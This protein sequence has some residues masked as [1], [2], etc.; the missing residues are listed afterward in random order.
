MPPPNPPSPEHGHIRT[1]QGSD[2]VY[3][4]FLNFVSTNT[5]YS[6]KPTVAQNYIAAGELA[7]LFL[8]IPVEH[9]MFLPIE[10]VCVDHNARPRSVIPDRDSRGE[11]GHLERITTKKEDPLL[12]YTRWK[13]QSKNVDKK[14]RADYEAY[15]NDYEA[16]RPDIQVHN[17]NNTV[18]YPRAKTFLNC[19]RAYIKFASILLGHQVV[20]KKKSAVDDY[21]LSLKQQTEKAIE[22]SVFE[23]VRQKQKDVIEGVSGD[24][25]KMAG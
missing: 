13:V 7:A 2:K 14:L 23:S 3:A 17:A 9:L 16:S 11:H 12:D 20:A 8:E 21:F 1:G 5:V 25:P 22:T 18:R 24:E 15:L 4:R 6:K 10:K 19:V